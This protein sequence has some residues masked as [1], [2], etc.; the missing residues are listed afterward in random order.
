[1][2]MRIGIV[3]L[4]VVGL[5]L[6][7]A[8]AAEAGKVL[9]LGGGGTPTSGA[10][11]NAFAFLTGRYGAANVDYMQA[12]ASSAGSEAGYDLLIISSTITSGDGRNKFQNST[13]GIV[14]WEEAIVDTGVGE[15]QLSVVN[16]PTGQTQI[17]IVDN[18]HPVTA[19]FSTGLLTIFTAGTETIAQNGSIGAGVQVLATES[20]SSDATLF[21]ADTG[22]AL[23]GDGTAGRPDTAAGR[24]VTFPITDN[25]FAN[26]NAGGL[27]LFGQATDWAG[28]IAPFVPEGLLVQYTFPTAHGAGVETG[29]GFN[30]TTVA[31]GVDALFDMAVKDTSGN[32]TIEISNPTPNYASQPVLRVDPDGS[33]AS[34]AQAIANDKYFEFEI[35]PED[36]FE[37]NLESLD[38]L[39]GRG[40]SSTPRGWG[41][42]T[43]LDDFAT[44]LDTAAIPTQ[45]PTV[46]GYSVDLSGAEFQGLMAPVTFRLYAFSTGN[47]ATFEIDDLTLR[48]TTRFVPEPATL[49]LLGLGALALV[50]RRR[51]T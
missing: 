48:G 36:M 39:A 32:I 25:G 10:D 40:G 33:S 43:S 42:A 37:L 31:P 41:L 38:F 45:R 51:R 44:I 22:A 4:I 16:K 34:L 28:N 47:G 11:D 6:G 50:R 15:F 2:R 29:S 9:F 27:K 20:G 24:R 49:S 21:I 7:L 30:P 14:N 18:S 5:A 8:G 23:L 46:T 26:L 35:Q 12:S 13:V 17:D 19:G 1:M 3:A